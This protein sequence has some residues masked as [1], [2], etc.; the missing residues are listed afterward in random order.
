MAIGKG[1]RMKVRRAA[2]NKAATFAVGGA[3]RCF[4]DIR[5]EVIAYEE[6][7]TES[8]KKRVDG[9]GHRLLRHVGGDL[10]LLGKEQWRQQDKLGSACRW[11]PGGQR[12]R[13]PCGYRG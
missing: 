12:R 9:F 1:G 13:G 6:L 7:G 2:H 5:R 11:P 4:E 8:I 3:A 10:L